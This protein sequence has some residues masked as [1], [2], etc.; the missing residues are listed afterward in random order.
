MYDSVVPLTRSLRIAGDALKLMEVHAE[1]D[2]GEAVLWRCVIA[3]I[4]GA[5]GKSRAVAA[6]SRWNEKVLSLF[7]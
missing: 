5:V 6:L 7:S 2:W 3:F 4:Q 1:A